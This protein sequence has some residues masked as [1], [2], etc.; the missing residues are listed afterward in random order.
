MVIPDMSKK[1]GHSGIWSGLVRQI[2]V[3]MISFFTVFWITE[4]ISQSMKMI[5]LS[6]DT[7]IS[8]ISDNT[9]I[10][11]NNNAIILSNRQLIIENNRHLTDMAG[12][13]KRDSR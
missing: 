8:R 3:A 9:A 5:K 12:Q 13:R 10:L 2:P 1:V 7:L 6:V 11:M 4:T